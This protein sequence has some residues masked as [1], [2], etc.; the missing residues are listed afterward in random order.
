[1]SQALQRI[2]QG[3]FLLS[4]LL[5][6]FSFEL[7]AQKK[8]AGV[9]LQAAESTPLPVMNK[10][11]Q[12]FPPGRVFAYA[13]HDSTMVHR[14]YSDSSTLD[15]SR[16][17][18]YF[19]QMKAPKDPTDGVLELLVNVDSVRYRFQSGDA[20]I[21]YDDQSN[22]E[23]TFPDLIAATVPVNREFTM[24][25]SPYWEVVST[26]GEM[27]D[28]LR[29]YIDQYGKGVLDSM[30]T[31]I[32]LNGIST[33]SLA[34]FSDVQKGTL[35]NARVHKDSTWRKPYFIKVDGIDCRDD[36]AATHIASY[37]RNVYTLETQSN[38]LYV[39]PGK[40]RLYKIE[41]M[42]DILDGKGKGRHSM[43][44]HKSGYITSAVSDFVTTMRAKIRNEVFSET[45][46]SVYSWK[47][48]GQ[49]AY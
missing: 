36:S 4:L 24:K 35:P 21:R 20:V 18:I 47:L 22:M 11:A 27:L 48:L 29:D 3:I 6:T 44:L 45:V 43:Q 1:M 30:R 19:M 39:L 13:Y 15:Y 7:E 34:Q 2:A 9:G 26:Q 49:L 38:N 41:N 32:W 23:M 8:G 5:I 10:L 31:F 14:I 28:W 46:R 16:D 40:Q 17:V 37:T 25:I 33:T 12:V 42:V